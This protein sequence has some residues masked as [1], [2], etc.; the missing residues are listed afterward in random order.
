MIPLLTREVAVGNI[1]I[2]GKSPLVLIGGPCA[3][4]SEKFT[5]KMASRIKKIADS[6]R[7]PYIFKSS[8]DKANRSSIRSYRGPVSS[9]DF[10]FWK[11]L[12]RNLKSR[13]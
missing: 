4:E 2:G 13:S 8:Y 7:I 6:L 12:R 3:I 5:L 9:R 11:K 10:G 1:K